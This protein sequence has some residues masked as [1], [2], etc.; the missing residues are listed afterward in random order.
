MDES[1]R[2]ILV[3]ME[4]AVLEGALAFLLETRTGHHVVQFH[5]ALPADGVR[6]F[7]AAVVSPALAGHADADVVIVLPNLASPRAGGTGRVR[8]GNGERLVQLRSHQQVIDLLDEQFPLSVSH[9]GP[10]A[11]E[12]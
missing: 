6:R 9:P 11:A 8:N 3:A 4:P 2:R 12:G 7:D 5:E 10:V 1:R